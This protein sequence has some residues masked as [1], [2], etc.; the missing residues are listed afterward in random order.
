MRYTGDGT[1]IGQA[2]QQLPAFATQ[3]PDPF[4]GRRNSKGNHHDKPKE[5]GGDER[6]FVN[7]VNHVTNR[8]E[9]IQPRIRQ[10]V[11]ET[12]K[13]GEEPQHAPVLNDFVKTSQFADGRNT[14]CDQKKTQRPITGE[15]RD[16]LDR[17]CAERLRG[18]G[19]PI[20]TLLVRNTTGKEKLLSGSVSSP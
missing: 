20:A 10:E 13:E 19:G 4:P 5:S 17:I 3:S 8:E 7:I 11:K 12:V 15:F 14:Q 2:M 18:S 9:L 6:T 16:V 1:D